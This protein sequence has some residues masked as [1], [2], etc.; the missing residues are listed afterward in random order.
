MPFDIAR[1][2]CLVP[3][4]GDGR[5]HLEGSAGMLVPE[6][7]ASAVATAMRA[8]VSSPGGVFPASQ[9]ADSIV[10]AAR[11]AVADLTGADPEGVVLGPSGA[12]LLRRLALALGDVW[13]LGDEVDVARWDEPTNQIPRVEAARGDG[14]VDRWG[15]VDI[16]TCELPAWQYETLVTPRTKLVALTAASGTVGT[17]PEIGRAH[18]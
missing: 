5:V 9:R 8:P 6:Q 3:A 12:V 4:L 15:E 17:R 10:N 11:R 16:E 13:T 2:R 1:M 18:V 14:G 7:V